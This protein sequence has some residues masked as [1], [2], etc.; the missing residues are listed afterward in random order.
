MI[1]VFRITPMDQVSTL[2]V[3]TVSVCR[4]EQYLGTI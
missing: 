3:E 4:I 1:K 2:K